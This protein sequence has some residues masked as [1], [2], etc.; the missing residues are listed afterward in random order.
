[1]AQ[2]RRRPI[3]PQSCAN[4][5]GGVPKAE[6]E[7]DALAA[8]QAA[9]EA[10]RKAAEE[11]A[12][13][14]AIASQSANARSLATTNQQDIGNKLQSTLSTPIQSG[15]MNYGAQ[16]SG[17]NPAAAKQQQITSMGGSA[18]IPMASPGAAVAAKVNS[19]SGGTNAVQN[20]YTM[21]NTT[22]LQFGGT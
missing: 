22:G 5:C 16:A 21:P 6:A 17:F 13:Q 11:A 8:Q 12:R 18:P 4:L 19:D 15:T 20:R 10:A 2:T 9:Q 7:A 3:S 1:M 14:Q